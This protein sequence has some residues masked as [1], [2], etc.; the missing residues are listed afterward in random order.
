MHTRPFA[1]L[2][3]L[4]LVATNVQAAGKLVVDYAWIRAAPPGASMLAGYATLTNTG[5]VRVIVTGA[6]SADFGDVSLHQSVQENGVERMLPLGDIVI[7]PG[8]HVDFA[9]GGKHFML[10]QPTR[11]LHVG[12]KVKIR[13]FCSASNNASVEFTIS[14]DAPPSH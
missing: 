1:V 4:I 6:D 12:D 5:D 3:L 2:I 14:Q 8:A 10:M 9:P 13:I 7:A 11:V